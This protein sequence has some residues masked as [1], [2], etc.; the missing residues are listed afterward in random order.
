L[1]FFNYSALIAK[2]QTVILFKSI[3]NLTAKDTQKTLSDLFKVFQK[4][5]KRKSLIFYLM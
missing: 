4:P 5:S 2:A 1:Y 3:L